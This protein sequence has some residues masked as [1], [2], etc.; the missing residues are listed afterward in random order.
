MSRP[1]CFMVM[2]FGRK[3]TGFGPDGPGPVEVDFDALWA[4]ALDPVIRNHGYEPVRADQDAGALIV[5][6]M[7]RR[8][9]LSDLV[10][11]DITIPNANV[12]YEI[13][14]RHA[15]KPDSCVL[16]A[17]DWANPLFDI[18]QMPRL[19]YPLDDGDVS[20]ATAATI[21]EQIENQI[22]GM[23]AGASP[24][25]QAVPGFP[26]D[27]DDHRVDAFKAEMLSL[28]SLLARFQSVREEWDKDDARA[29]A[30]ELRD[31]LAAQE[32]LN[33]GV[34]I[35]M[36]YL[37][38]VRA[39]WTDM[40]A[41]IDA[42]PERLRTR[43][44][45]QEQRMLAIGKNGDHKTAIAELKQLVET[46]GDSS[47]RQGLI[48]GR[49]KKLWNEALAEEKVNRGKVAGH[50]QN[51]IRH[52]EAGM[53]LDL[54][55]YYSP[56]NL[57]RLYRARGKEGDAD[58]ARDAAAVAL[59]GC[60]RAKLLDPSDE[61]INPTLLGAA[62]D[63]QN[64]VR[65]QELADEVLSGNPDDWKLETTVHDLRLSASQADDPDI[66]AQLADVFNDLNEQ[67]PDDL[68]GP[69]L[70]LAETQEPPR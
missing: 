49:Y 70:D 44:G 32:A 55:D 14:I 67:L 13:G 62:F 43:N 19:V 18:D 56:C 11:A 23:R 47:E 22:E 52:Y 24:V 7:I 46:T 4:K 8:L 10:V 1:I 53:R 2:P 27:I 26:N 50:L 37:L 33:D 39:D 66:R 57:P 63:S 17:A 68:R 21:T 42:L 6:E 51:A 25:Y 38:R 36:M 54:N 48:G 12:Y 3:P 69:A 45:V 58:R 34:A 35:E 29:A 31:E 20:D 5:V 28:N 15:A 9:A 16:I 60:E 40:L 41:W 65:V 64:V 30:L 61:W 59:A